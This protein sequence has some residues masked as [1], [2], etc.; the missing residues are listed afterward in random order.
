MNSIV[1]GAT[2][3]QTRLSDFHFHKIIKQGM[4]VREGQTEFSYF[5]K[6]NYFTNGT[7]AYNFTF[8]F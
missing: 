7:T 6:K 8:M 3:S 4:N 5:D 1:H 2:E